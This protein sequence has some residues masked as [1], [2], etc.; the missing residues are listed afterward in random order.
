MR[1]AKEDEAGGRKLLDNRMDGR[2]ELARVTV[3]GDKI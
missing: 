3:V 2:L 1:I